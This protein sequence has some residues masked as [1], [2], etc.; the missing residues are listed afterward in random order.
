MYVS[1]L[2]NDLT[3]FVTDEPAAKAPLLKTLDLHAIA[4]AAQLHQM[5]RAQQLQ[6]MLLQQQQ[7]EVFIRAH[8]IPCGN[9]NDASTLNP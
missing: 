6:H 9:W 4:A 1:T 8:V 7:I 5:Q 2:Y 3:K